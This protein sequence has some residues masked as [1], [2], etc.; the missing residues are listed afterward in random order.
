[1]NSWLKKQVEHAATWLTFLLTMSAAVYGY[2]DIV[3]RLARIETRNE[4][5]DKRQLVIEEKLDRV[6]RAFVY[7]GEGANI[8]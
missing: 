7:D 2:V 6:A 5:A 8:K 1:M 3:V 4:I